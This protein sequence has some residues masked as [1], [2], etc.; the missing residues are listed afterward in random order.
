MDQHSAQTLPIGS[1][2]QGGS[3]GRLA[4]PSASSEAVDA[5]RDQTWRAGQGA[6]TCQSARLSTCP[7]FR[8]ASAIPC[9]PNTMLNSTKKRLRNHSRTLAL[10]V[11]VAG[12]LYLAGSYALERLRDVQEQ[13]GEER[14]ARERSVSPPVCSPS[15]IA[16]QA[17]ISMFSLLMD[18]GSVQSSTALH[19]EPGRLH[20]HPPRAAPDPVLPDP[21]GPRRRATD[22]RP[23]A[24][25]AP[26]PVPSDPQGRQNRPG[27]V[28]CLACW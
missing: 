27:R 11:G 7:R 14:R 25:L 9:L 16:S 17:D 13:A 4:R 21:D 18:A 2:Q 26:K 12:G 20:L 24:A 19:P 22:A 5:W 15:L 10:T 3:S 6:G 23:P 8:S 28:G 1:Q